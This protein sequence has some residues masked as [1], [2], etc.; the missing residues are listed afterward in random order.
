MK[1]VLKVS[2]DLKKYDYYFVGIYDVKMDMYIV[3]DE[4]FDMG[5]GLWYDYGKFYVS[6]M[7]FD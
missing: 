7:F 2:L 6:K 5:L 4:R 1:Y 3:D